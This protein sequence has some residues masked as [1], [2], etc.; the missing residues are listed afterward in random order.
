MDPFGRMKLVAGG[1]IGGHCILTSSLPCPSLAMAAPAAAASAALPTHPV[2]APAA[3]WVAA[4]PSPRTNRRL[5]TNRG[6]C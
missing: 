6:R 5:G 2:A 4:A 1:D 3:L